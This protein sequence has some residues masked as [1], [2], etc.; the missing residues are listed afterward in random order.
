[1]AEKR[2]MITPNGFFGYIFRCVKNIF[3]FF[4]AEKYE[5]AY[6]E[7]KELKEFVELNYEQVRDW[8]NLCSYVPYYRLI[9]ASDKKV[10]EEIL[11]RFELVRDQL[12]RYRDDDVAKMK[13]SEHLWRLLEGWNTDLVI[14]LFW[15]R[16]GNAY[17]RKR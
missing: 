6:S 11:E 12:L 8:D 10:L 17:K 1:M 4:N 2:K 15:D 3:I 7:L 14:E 5:E 13:V 16:V 9:P